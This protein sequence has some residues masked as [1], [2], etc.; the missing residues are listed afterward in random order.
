MPDAHKDRVRDNG[1]NSA[2]SSKPAR[3]KVRRVFGVWLL[4]CRDINPFPDAIMK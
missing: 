4:S 3:M 2:H 1:G